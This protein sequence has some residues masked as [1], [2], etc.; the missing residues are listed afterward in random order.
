MRTGQVFYKN[1]LAGI[2]TENDDGYIF[3]YEEA[4]LN[5]PASKPLSLTL[6]LQQQVYESKAFI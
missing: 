6:P 5:N 3:Q 2:I 4:Y 1:S